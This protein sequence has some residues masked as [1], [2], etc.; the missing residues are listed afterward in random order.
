MCVC[1][2]YVCVGFSVLSRE[3][4]RGEMGREREK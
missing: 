3:V 4:G 1:A 2:C